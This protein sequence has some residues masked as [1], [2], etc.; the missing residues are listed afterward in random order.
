MR[1]KALYPALLL[2]TTLLLGAC[3]GKDDPTKPGGSSPVAAL[4][5]S[6]ELLKK[7]DFKNLWKHSLPPADY[8]TLRADW[9]RHMQNRGPVTAA[10]RVR[11]NQAMQQLTAPDA[12]K[13]L[14]AELL[15][16]LDAMEKKYGDQVPVLI[17]VGGALV[18]KSVADKPSLTAEQKAQ[19]DAVMDVITPWAQKTPWF[20]KAKAKQSIGVVVDTARKLDLKSPEQLRAMDFDTAMDKYATGFV[21]VRQLL[22]IYGLSIKHTLDSVKMSQSS[23]DGDH[24]VVKIDY[25]LLGKPLSTQSNMVKVDGRWYSQGMIKNVRASHQKL[26]ASPAPAKASSQMTPSATAATVATPDKRRSR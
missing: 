9:S 23:I 20:D 12:Q 16:K 14:D 7:N 24:A 22:D 4:Q 17:S 5:S 25:S 10:D 15:P 13:K 1:T 26:E 21:G 8:A 2:C 6:V 18:K 11:F 19:A 3:H